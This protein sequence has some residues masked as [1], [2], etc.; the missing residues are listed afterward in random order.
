MTL[1]IPYPEYP[2]GAPQPLFWPGIVAA[3]VDIMILVLLASWV[4]SQ[5]RKALKG[6]EIEKPF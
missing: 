4:F 2:A 6:E 3:M 1:P 5:A